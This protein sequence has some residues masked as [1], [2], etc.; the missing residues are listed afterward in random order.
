MKQAGDLTL[1]LTYVIGNAGWTALYDL[2][3][4]EADTAAFAA[5]VSGAGHATHAAKTGQMWR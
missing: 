2:R 5:D 4:S 1:D 3:L